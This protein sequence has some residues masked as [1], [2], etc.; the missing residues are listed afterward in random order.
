[1]EYTITDTK[2]QKYHFLSKNLNSMCAFSNLGKEY[3]KITILLYLM[4][5]ISKRPK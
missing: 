3:I 5:R 1:M 4:K 2:T